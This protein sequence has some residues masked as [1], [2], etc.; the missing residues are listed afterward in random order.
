MIKARH[1]P[2][3][4]RFFNW[5]IEHI[6]KS[7]FREIE[8]EGEWEKCN[9]AS[10]VIG[11]HFSWWDGFWVLYLNN[12][13]LKKRFHAMML[14]KQL[15]QHKFLSTIGAF[16]VDPGSRS[17]VESIDYCV[18]LLNNP[19]NCVTIYPQGHIASIT[20]PVFSFGKGIEKILHKSKPVQMLFY[21]AFI[22]YFSHRKPSLYLY[23]SE[24]EPHNYKAVELE[25]LYHQFYNDSKNKQA[26]KAR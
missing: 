24:I 11:N 19:T 17:V 12:R 20:S 2:I 4:T 3:L 13:F 23:I 16:S 14:E 9:K 26:L 1:H 18:Q 15:A 8:I 22:D 21:A 10:L 25:V 5:Y 7:D 6:L